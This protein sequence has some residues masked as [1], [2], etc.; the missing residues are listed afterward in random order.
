MNFQ[1]KYL[2][3]DQVEESLTVSGRLKII[4]QAV[5]VISTFI[6]RNPQDKDLDVF[7]GNMNVMREQLRSLQDE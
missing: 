7:V 4:H 2:L 1:E 3:K 6:E 5:Q